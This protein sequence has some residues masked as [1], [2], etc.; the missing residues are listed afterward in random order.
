[1]GVCPFQFL[2]VFCVFCVPVQRGSVVLQFRFHGIPDDDGL[3]LANLDSILSL[4]AH[5]RAGSANEI[6]V[7][8]LVWRIRELELLANLVRV[9]LDHGDIA[10]GE[11]VV[12]LLPVAQKDDVQLPFCVIDAWAVELQFLEALFTGDG[13]LPGE[14]DHHLLHSHERPLVVKLVCEPVLA[15]VEVG[16]KRLENRA[17]VHLRVRNQTT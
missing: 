13:E 6:G 17:A 15:V 4:L 5:L 11:V 2:C 3:L 9:G 14:V 10:L 8:I 1:M 16:V 7:A 12:L